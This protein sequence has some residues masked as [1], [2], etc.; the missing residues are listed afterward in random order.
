[1]AVVVYADGVWYDHNV[2]LTGPMDHAFWL[3]SVVFDGAR[4]FGGHAPDLDLHCRRLVNSARAMRIT[5][6]LTA[7]EIEGLCREGIRR[8]PKAAELYVRPMF[9]CVGGFIVP[10]ADSTRFCLAVYDMPLPAP[11]GFSACVSKYRR[12]RPDQAPTD[13]KASCLYPNSTRANFEAR[14]RGFDN[15]IMLD[16][17]GNVAEFTTANL[18]IAKNGTAITPK[19][20]GMLL[21]GVTR[22]RVA[23]LLREAGIAVE[24]RTVTLADVFAADEVFCTGN[25]SKVVPVTRVEDKHYQPGPV[26]ARARELYFAYARATPPVL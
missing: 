6:T 16:A 23:A 26:G 1:M 9:Y 22:G 21:A 5:P 18:W 11:A 25:Y 2:A 17:D 19:A 24:E 10:E 4:A 7:E 14:E 12:P 3:S 20:N 8:F 15:A 13:A